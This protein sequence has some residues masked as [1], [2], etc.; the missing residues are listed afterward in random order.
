MIFH[1]IMNF[2]TKIRVM[3]SINL[4]HVGRVVKL[5][6]VPLSEERTQRVQKINFLDLI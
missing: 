4:E 5:S 1:E 3:M 6:K 2:F